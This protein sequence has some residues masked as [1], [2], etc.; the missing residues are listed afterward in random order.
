MAPQHGSSLCVTAQDRSQVDLTCIEQLNPCPF[1]CMQA[2]SPFHLY[3]PFVLLNR[4][5]MAH[6]MLQ[7]QKYCIYCYINKN[8]PQ[9][10][11]V[12]FRDHF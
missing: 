1:C 3:C 7:C 5:E 2:V 11:S 10:V 9:K 12:N 4:I 6:P 8:N